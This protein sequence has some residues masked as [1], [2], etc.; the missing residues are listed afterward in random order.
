MCSIASD[1]FGSCAYSSFVISCHVRSAS[2]IV[3]RSPLVPRV[4][5]L[6]KARRYHS[7]AV[8]SLPH[9][10][11][12][13][14]RPSQWSVTQCSS[15]RTCLRSRRR[16]HSPQSPHHH[17]LLLRR[18]CPSAPT[19][20]DLAQEGSAAPSCHPQGHLTASQASCSQA[21]L[22]FRLR[23]LPLPPRGC[24]ASRPRSRSVA[25]CCHSRRRQGQ[26]LRPTLAPLPLC[27]P[28]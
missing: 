6:R 14:L 23:L 11:E 24:P 2:L 20:F 25:I 26:A 7:G 28:Q 13:S 1:L 19:A 16:S 18:L 9:L 17:L 10:L 15:Y 21:L 8:P 5:K 22:H 3:L 4:G 27:R 12:R